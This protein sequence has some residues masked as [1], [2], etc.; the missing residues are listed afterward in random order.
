MLN[1]P[2]AQPLN[3]VDV[4]GLAIARL[5]HGGNH[6][7]VIYQS[8]AVGLTLAHLAWHH[9]LRFERPDDKYIWL[10]LAPL[11]EMNKRV[12]AAFFET[13]RNEHPNI[14]YGFDMRGECFDESGNFIPPPLGKG[15]TCATFVLATFRA[16]GHH[17]VDEETW[18]TRAEDEIWQEQIL[19]LLTQ[20]AATE[21]IQALENDIGAKRYKPEEVAASGIR[22][23]TPSTFDDI[24]QLAD[25][26]LRELAEVG[27]WQV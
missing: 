7:G 3:A 16:H 14:P 2:P 9:D 4:I 19:Q 18:P 8:T 13:L 1:R 25:G 24:K 22:M 12:S 11:D 17:L 5:S 26:I 21:H 6:I 10:D 20:S 23:S 27:P 15:L